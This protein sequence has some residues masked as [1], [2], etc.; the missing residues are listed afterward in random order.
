M[1]IQEDKEMYCSYSFLVQYIRRT[2]N[3]QI[4]KKYLE[5]KEGPDTKQQN[6]KLQGKTNEKQKLSTLGTQETE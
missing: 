2:L 4:R 5:I 3:I 1:K 6:F